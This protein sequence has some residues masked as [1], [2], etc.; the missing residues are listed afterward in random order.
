[1]AKL[2]EAGKNGNADAPGSAKIR[3]TV[4]D[5][6]GRLFTT[7]AEGAISYAFP[8]SSGAGRLEVNHRESDTL[9]VTSEICHMTPFLRL[10][11]SVP[12]QDNCRPHGKSSDV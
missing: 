5:T 1:V 9:F 11:H 2:P 6:K 3:C 4:R 7:M 10:G 8:T 12:S